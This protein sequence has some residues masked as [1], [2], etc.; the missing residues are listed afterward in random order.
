MAPG[1][2]SLECGARILPTDT[3][4]IIFISCFHQLHI[5]LGDM[6]ARRHTFICLTDLLC[7]S[8][9]Q[10]A[11]NISP[12]GVDSGEHQRPCRIGP[13]INWKIRGKQGHEAHAVSKEIF[14]RDHSRHVI[15]RLELLATCNIAQK[16]PPQNKHQELDHVL[17]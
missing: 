6:E 16:L 8:A 10:H 9:G 2:F 14:L 13:S 11:K 17:P 3:L 15:C 4:A 5:M 7:R 12:H 1:V